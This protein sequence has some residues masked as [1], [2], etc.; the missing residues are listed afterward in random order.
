MAFHQAGQTVA[1]IAK[2]FDFHRTT[3][4][5]YLKQARKTLHTAPIDPAFQERARQAYTEIGAF[6]H[7]G[8]SPD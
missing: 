6:K 2:R 1:Q 3:V 8:Q 4:A 7:N 5:R